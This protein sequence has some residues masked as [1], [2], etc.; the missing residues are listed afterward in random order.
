MK[1]VYQCNIL[2]S[3]PLFFSESIIVRYSR[4]RKYDIFCTEAVIVGNTYKKT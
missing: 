1:S 4:I 3:V 2:L